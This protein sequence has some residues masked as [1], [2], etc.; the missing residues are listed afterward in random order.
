MVTIYIKRYPLSLLT[1]LAIIVLS[2]M[3]FPE[4]KFA[5]D[6]PL[7]DKWVH[8]VMYG[9]LSLVIWV[10]RARK[11]VAPCNTWGYAI[12]YGLLGSAFLGGVLELVQQYCTTTRNGDWWD[13]LADAIGAVL[14]SIV[15]SIIYRVIK[16]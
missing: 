16:K 8:F 2:V 12:T 9:F 3:P 5:E 4:V 1:T 7:A 11:A 14:G 13:F 6:I 10:E 15:G